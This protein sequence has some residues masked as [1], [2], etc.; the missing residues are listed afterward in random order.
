MKI[1]LRIWLA[2]LIIQPIIF[3]FIIGELAI[4]VVPVEIL[5]SIPGLVLFWIAV[6]AITALKAPI[7]LKWILLLLSAITCA[8]LCNYIFIAGGSGS[9]FD[10]SESLLFTIPAPV[11][12]VMGIVINGESVNRHLI[13]NEKIP[14]RRKII[15]KHIMNTDRIPDNISS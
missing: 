13:D 10:D 3:L 6:Q 1:T 8:F 2:A 9:I 7:G 5:G 11:A 4:F 15:R 14:G 12:A